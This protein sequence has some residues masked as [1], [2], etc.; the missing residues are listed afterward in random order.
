[1]GNKV[2]RAALAVLVGGAIFGGG[3]LTLDGWAGRTLW[4][5]A[6]FTG[7]EYATDS[8]ALFDLFEDGE[9]TPAADAT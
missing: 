4:T 1:M 6:V 2:K 9:P 7:M 3:C 8:D 5:A